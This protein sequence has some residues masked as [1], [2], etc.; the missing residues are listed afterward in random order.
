M[1][2]P[3]M[4]RLSPLVL[5]LLFALLFV[6]WAPPPSPNAQESPSVRLTLLSQTSW[7]CP[8][9]TAD[10]PSEQAGW[11]CPPGRELDLRLRAQNLGTEPLGELAIGVTLYS[12]VLYRSAYEDSLVSDPSIVIDASTLPRQDAIEPG[13]ARDFE[14]SL[15]LEQGIDPEQSGVYPVKVDLRSGI[16]SVA[17][18]RT[19]AIFLVREPEIP[20]GLSWTFVLAHPIVFAPDG[21]FTDPSLE[22]ALGPGGRL[23]GE[24]RA[25]LELASDPTAAPVDVAV[26]PMLLTQLGRMRQGYEVSVDGD[27][28]RVPAGEGGAALAERALEDLRTIAAA[29]NVEVTALPFSAPEI[30]SLYGGGLGRDVVVQLE[31]GREVASTFVGTE[32]VEEILRPPGAILDDP[33]LRGLSAA[34]IR[35]LLVGPSTVELPEQ[36]LDFAGPATTSLGDVSLAAIVPEPSSEA[37]LSSVVAEDPVLAAQVL[38]GELTAIWQEAPGEER[39]IALVL[40]EDAPLPG[41]FFP[42]LVRDIATA[43]WLAPAAAKAFVETYPPIDASVLANPSFRR[44]PTAYVTSIRQARRRIDTLRS[45]LPSGSLEPDRLETMLLLA[46]ARQFLISTSDGLAFIDAV[47]RSVRDSVDDLA[48]ETVQS[49]TLTSESAGIPVTVSNEGQHVLRLSVRLDSPWL[50]EEPTAALVLAPGDTRTV[51]LQAELR[52]TGRFPVQVQMV[53]PSGRVIGQRGLAV[54]STAFNRIALLITIGA[55]L[56][57]IALW[58]RRF[59][60]NRATRRTT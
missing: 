34:G 12:R 24:I 10:L 52:S 55:A 43:P 14:I 16:T 28:R 60:P 39:G 51:R 41:P 40:S 42:P 25:L 23:N 45:M 54:R 44:F 29:P 2:R 6:L 57:L 9:A 27:T 48:L 56:V 17:E 30:P 50:L 20:I 1:A 37:V 38:L 59:L 33:T 36:P 31:R 35:T 18:L 13:D 49:V 7:N 47:K 15:P 26:S 32:M 46:E 3:I 22:I 53:S 58:A 19:P 5:A 4:R 11:S 21:T 8:T